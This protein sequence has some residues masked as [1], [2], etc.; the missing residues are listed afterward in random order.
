MDNLTSYTRSVGGVSEP[1]F[2]SIFV[3]GAI[4]GLQYISKNNTVI[5]CK[6]KQKPSNL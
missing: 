3:Q 6:E 2:S 5:S 4:V 1:V